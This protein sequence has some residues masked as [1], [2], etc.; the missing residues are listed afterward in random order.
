MVVNDVFIDK[1]LAKPIVQWVLSRQKDQNIFDDTPD[2][3]TGYV[4]CLEYIDKKQDFLTANAFPYDNYLTI[5]KQIIKGFG[6][7]DNLPIEEN[8]GFIIVYSEKGHRVHPH[9]DTNFNSEGEGWE[10]NM[11]LDNEYIGDVIHT[12]FNVLVSKPIK[13]GNPIIDGIEYSVRENEA[14][15]CHSGIKEHSTNEIEGDKPRILL[16]FGHW[17]P[18]QFLIDKGIYKPE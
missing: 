5:R 2:H 6:Y 1:N 9:R 8:M 11:N 18:K 10:K 14:W 7:E 3:P 16:S 17:V 4:T 15:V 13:G 12:R